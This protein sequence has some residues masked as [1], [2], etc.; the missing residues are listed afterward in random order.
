MPALGTTRPRALTALLAL[1]LLTTLLP[2]AGAAL[3]FTVRACV[4][5]RARR[6]AGIA[7]VLSTLLSAVVAESA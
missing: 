5:V 2:P 4:H 1:L 6:G 3:S 7:N